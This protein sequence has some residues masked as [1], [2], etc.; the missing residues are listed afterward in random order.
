[1]TPTP[2]VPVGSSPR[3]V[4]RRSSDAP[5][6]RTTRPAAYYHQRRRGRNDKTK[7][8]RASIARDPGR[9]FDLPVVDE[10]ARFVFGRRGRSEPLR[11][12]TA[13]QRKKPMEKLNGADA[14]ITAGAATAGLGAG[15][16]SKLPSARLTSTR[17]ALTSAR[18]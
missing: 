4:V 6:Q 1:N 12:R 13:S 3:R 2:A 9:W 11:L 8:A 15:L 16:I 10:A 18:W 17:C 14:G 5:S 7:T